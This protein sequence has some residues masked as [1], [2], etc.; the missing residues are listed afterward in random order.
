MIKALKTIV[1]NK[2]KKMD[3]QNPMTNG[4]NKAI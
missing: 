2:T 1:K 3:S 4:K